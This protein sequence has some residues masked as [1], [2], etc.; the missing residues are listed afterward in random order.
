M[1]SG[2]KLVPRLNRYIYS[3]K[4]LHFPPEVNGE[5]ILCLEIP[6]SLQHTVWTQSHKDVGHLGIQKLTN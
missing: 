4:L 5:T 3:D 2:S 6:G 1:L